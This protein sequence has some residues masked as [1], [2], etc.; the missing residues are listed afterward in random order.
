MAFASENSARSLVTSSSI[1]Y[2]RK[3]AAK[4]VCKHNTQRTQECKLTRLLERVLVGNLDDTSL[5]RDGRNESVVHESDRIVL[6]TTLDDQVCNASSV[7]KGRNV[8]SNL[9]ESESEVLAERTGELRLGLVANNHDGRVGIDG[10]LSVRDRTA[11]GFRDR[12]VNTTAETLVGGH[13]DEEFALGR[14]L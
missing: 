13:D 10:V 5:I 1:S 3:P 12:G 4:S 2:A 7:R 9:V 8:A 6:D 14:R 11:G